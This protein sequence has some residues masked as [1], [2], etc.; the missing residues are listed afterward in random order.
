MADEEINYMCY[1]ISIIYPK[2]LVRLT[3]YLCMFGISEKIL[4]TLTGCL[5]NIRLIE[6]PKIKKN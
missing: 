4:S 1:F 2:S 6:C 3:K 5:T